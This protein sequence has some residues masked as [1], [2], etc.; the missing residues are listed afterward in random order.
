MGFVGHDKHSQIVLTI[1]GEVLPPL[2]QQN[3]CEVGTLEMPR[4]P[5]FLNVA[6]QTIPAEDGF[7]AAEIGV[8]VASL[9]AAGIDATLLWHSSTSSGE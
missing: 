1:L 8:V 4:F 2:S 7:V 5:R 9:L 3:R 6:V